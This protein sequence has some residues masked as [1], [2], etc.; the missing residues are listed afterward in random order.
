MLL[1][2]RA[3]LYVDEVTI[4]AERTVFKAE[5]ADIDNDECFHHTYTKNYLQRFKKESLTSRLT[6]A[7]D[8]DG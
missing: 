6:A 1:H 8:I 7:Q 5:Q 4:D 2:P 3:A